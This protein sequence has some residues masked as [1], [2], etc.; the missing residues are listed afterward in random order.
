MGVSM[1]DKR[2]TVEYDFGYGALMMYR[3]AVAEGLGVG[4]E[5]EA[6]FYWGRRIGYG[7]KRKKRHNAMSNYYVGKVESKVIP[8]IADFLYAGDCNA[9]FNHKQ[10]E[11][12]YKVLK[13]ITLPEDYNPIIECYSTKFNIHEA[14]LETFKE[15]C[16]YR[17]RGVEWY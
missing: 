17:S 6:S 5:Y 2:R 3:H 8:A 12:I 11:K 15:G 1:H 10:C 4:K 7:P 16:A 14:F 9:S 13:S